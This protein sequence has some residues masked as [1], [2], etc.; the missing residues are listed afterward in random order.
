[1]GSSDSKCKPRR[2]L[3]VAGGGARGAYSFGCQKALHEAGVYFEAVAA[4][5]AGALNGAIW[6]S[7][8][9]AAG[10]ALWRRMAPSNTY[11]PRNWPGFL[12]VALWRVLF[13][14][15][16]GVGLVASRIVHGPVAKEVEQPVAL[17]AA[18]LLLIFGSSLFAYAETGELISYAYYWFVVGCFGIYQGLRYQGAYVRT[19][20][21]LAAFGSLTTLVAEAPRKLIYGLLTGSPQA[22]DHA[23]NESGFAGLA[24][25]LLSAATFAFITLAAILL[26]FV[27]MN[28][29]S[30]LTM[31]SSRPL[32]KTIGEFLTGRKLKLPFYATVAY[33]AGVYDPDRQRWSLTFTRSECRVRQ[34]QPEAD[35]LW[36]PCYFRVD[37][38]APDQAVDVLAATAA[39]PFG[40]V[41]SVWIDGRHYVDGGLADNEPIAPL[42]HLNLDEIWLLRLEPGEPSSDDHLRTARELL[43]R[44]RL[45]DL[46]R[47]APF[48]TNTDARPPY[49]SGGACVVP[50]PWN[51]PSPVLRFLAPAQP[52]GGLF[53]GLLN[54]TPEFAAQ[55]IQSGYNETHRWLREHQAA[56]GPRAARLEGTGLGN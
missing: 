44:E 2:G 40:F 45:V 53:D 46:P 3:V 23:M 16:V 17:A 27:V 9:I 54:F 1:M 19:L 52:L 33:C 29:L 21:Y 26:F 39:L 20:G 50:Y 25:M 11:E 56:V 49:G 15:G 4:T 12:P 37:E 10:E 43:R 24:A 38:L 48:T 22:A 5:S 41:S 31:L 28:R 6:S 30:S 32:R 47:P 35:E 36:V 8:D 13:S 14:I 34:Y 55:C 18:I 7:G 51:G 42:L